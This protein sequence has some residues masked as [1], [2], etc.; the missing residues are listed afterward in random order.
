MS[1]NRNRRSLQG[2]GCCQH[3]AGAEFADCRGLSKVFSRLTEDPGKY[4]EDEKF[5]KD[6]QMNT[7]SYKKKG[8]NKAQ[9]RK[10]MFLSFNYRFV[11]YYPA[12]TV[13]KD[14]CL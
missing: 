4:N 13:P 5:E 6:I 3:D 12:S 1:E 2:S 10:R 11:T 14:V 8:M 7:I 9:G